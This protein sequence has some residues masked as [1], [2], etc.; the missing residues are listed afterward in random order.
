[1]ARKMMRMV[2]L[3]YN[4]IRALQLDALRGSDLVVDQLSFKQTLDVIIEFRVHFRGLGDRPQLL[5]KER[6]HV[7]ER[8]AERT[9]GK[10]PG[11]SEPRVLKKRPKSFQMLT[12][13]RSEFT[14]I[15][16]RNHYRAAA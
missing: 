12:Q 7:E 6:E 4:L 1:M 16:H 15:P 2:Q 3:S 10:R 9:L 14:E 5:L 11:R 13:S 8:I